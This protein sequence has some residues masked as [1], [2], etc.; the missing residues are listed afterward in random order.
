L[1]FSCQTTCPNCGSVCIARDQAEEGYICFNCQHHFPYGE[2]EE[3]FKYSL[4]LVDWGL[5]EIPEWVFERHYLKKL[6]LSAEPS[7]P[8]HAPFVNCIT[9]IPDKIGLMTDLEELDLSGNMISVIPPEIKNCKS[10]RELYLGRN[11]ITKIPEE[12]CELRNLEA[13][14]L[15]Y[16]SIKS[17]PDKFGSL[18]NLKFLNL[19]GNGL[20][21]LPKSVTSLVNL[22]DLIITGNSGLYSPPY[23]I[24][25]KGLVAITD[26]FEKSGNE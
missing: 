16:N 4:D 2:A 11:T 17:L 25:L 3:E 18:T 20:R 5:V 12:F 19:E 24:A 14:N 13:L 21:T 9:S 10:L 26:W 22:E 15:R 1:E 23:A 7:D 6:D 8:F